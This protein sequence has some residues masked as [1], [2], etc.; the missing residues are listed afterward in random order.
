MAIDARCNAPGSRLIHGHC[1]KQLYLYK[2]FGKSMKI[3]NR[4]KKTSRSHF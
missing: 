1:R 4:E 3:H 2:Q